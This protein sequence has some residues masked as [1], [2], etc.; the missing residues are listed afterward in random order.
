MKKKIIVK[1]ID[2]LI[3]IISKDKIV[4]EYIIYVVEGNKQSK[5]YLE[6]GDEAK[7]MRVNELLLLNFSSEYDKISDIVEEISF[8]D[9]YKIKKLS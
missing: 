6:I 3:S 5:A 1:E 7:N 9:F 2:K 4:T 8:N